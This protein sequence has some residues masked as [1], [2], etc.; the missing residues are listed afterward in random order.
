MTT[1]KHW[2]EW[3][4][5]QFSASLLMPENTIWYSLLAIQQKNGIRNK[6]TIFIDNQYDNQRAFLLTI[7][8]LADYFNVAK[9]NIEYRLSELGIIKYG[10]NIPKHWTKFL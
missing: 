8:E 9:I 1:D 7:S 10:N 3:Q 2:V 6:G 5:N 4:A